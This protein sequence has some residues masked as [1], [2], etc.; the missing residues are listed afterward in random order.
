MR[1]SVQICCRDRHSECALLLQSLRQQ[2]FRNWD[3]VIIDECQTPLLMNHFVNC[4]INRI[5]YEGHYVF[6]FNN[7]FR[8]GVCFA[9]N[10]ALE[11]DYFN[12]EYILRV[13]DDVIL[14][15]DYIMRLFDVIE[16]GYDIASGVTPS[17]NLSP[18]EREIKMQILN[19]KEFDKEGN[20]IKYGDDCGGLFM[21]SRILPAHEFRSC[22]LFRS[23]IFERL[24]YEKNLSPV[25]F[26]EEAFLS[27]RALALGYKI[28]IDTGAVAWHL[29][30]PSGGCRY[31][32]YAEKVKSDDSYFKDWAKK[33]Y[34]GSRRFR[35]AIK[36]D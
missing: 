24:K 11:K 13:D 32:D 18:V 4:L 8:Q 20:I 21:E 19:R 34:L 28:G 26:R 9:R 36:G 30:T 33:F 35:D 23:K 1:I 31:P 5:R 22:A 3:L 25:G 6:V 15:S 27:F 7:M 10:L 14:E 16:K 12:N 17:L 29:Q 2:S